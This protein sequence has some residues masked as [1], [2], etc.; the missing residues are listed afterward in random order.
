M[1]G[2]QKGMISKNANGY[3]MVRELLKGVGVPRSLYGYKLCKMTKREDEHD[4]K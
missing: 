1:V 4:T 2:M 3:R